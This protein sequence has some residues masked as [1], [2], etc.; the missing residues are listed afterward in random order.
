MRNTDT[1][2]LS[3]HAKRTTDKTKLFCSVVVSNQQQNDAHP[4]NLFAK[5]PQKNDAC[6][7][8]QF[9]P[10]NCW[11]KTP[12]IMIM[13]E[14][15]NHQNMMH[16]HTICLLNHSK[17]ERCMPTQFIY[18]TTPKRMIHAHTIYLSNPPKRMMHAH[19]ICS[20]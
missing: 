17:K 12:K 1:I 11:V 16:A 19:T 14:T 9:V 5:P 20:T 3:N 10:P 7:P 4:H 18:Q 2:G 8:T 13:N 6:I 15:S